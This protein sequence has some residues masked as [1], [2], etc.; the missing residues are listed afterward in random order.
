[1]KD[2]ASY[3]TGY[4]VRLMEEAVEQGDKLSEALVNEIVTQRISIDWLNL[5]NVGVLPRRSGLSLPEKSS[6]TES[7]VGVVSLTLVNEAI[8]VCFPVGP[9]HRVFN[10]GGDLENCILLLNDVFCYECLLVNGDDDLRFRPIS[11]Y[12][13]GM[14]FVNSSDIGL[15]YC[16]GLHRLD[17]SIASM[18]SN[19]IGIVV[20]FF[21][22]T[23]LAF[24]R[25][26]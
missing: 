21:D 19:V 8:V 23:R 5:N 16:K 18:A 17:R 4:A 7:S 1:M 24:G 11:F 14:V 10:R 2:C 3:V 9:V 6:L 20:P 26:C 12:G 22:D 25:V 13:A 15:K